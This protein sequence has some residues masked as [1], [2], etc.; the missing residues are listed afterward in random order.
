MAIL[1][2][3][4]VALHAQTPERVQAVPLAAGKPAVLRFWFTA[5]EPV[6]P[7]WRIG[8]VMP[9]TLNLG[10][11]QFADS[12]T[13]NGGLDVSVRQDTVWVNRSGAGDSLKTG[14][15]DVMV[16]MVGLPENIDGQ[17]EFSFIT[18][19]ENVPLADRRRMKMDAE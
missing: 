1:G 3:M 8:L 13:L 16:A 6:S 10:S 2:L 18:L 5:E 11:V 14:R 15:F 19:K 12:R 4:A 17:F 7:T 9:R